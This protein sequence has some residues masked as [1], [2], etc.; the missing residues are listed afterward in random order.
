[1]RM[2][3]TTREGEVKQAITKKTILDT[4][5]IKMKGMRIGKYEEQTVVVKIAKRQAL[6]L[7]KARGLTMGC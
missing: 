5:G 4:G 3:P 1:M 7:I 6:P 2:D